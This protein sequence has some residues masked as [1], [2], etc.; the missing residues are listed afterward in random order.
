MKRVCWASETYKDLA[1]GFLSLLMIYVGRPVLCSQ[2]EAHHI[3]VTHYCALE[4][5][6]LPKLFCGVVVVHNDDDDSAS[7]YETTT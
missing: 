3:Q 5:H 4:P 6:Q 7:Y 1:L 2:G